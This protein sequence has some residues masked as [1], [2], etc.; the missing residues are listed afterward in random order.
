MDTIE[1]QITILELL[2]MSIQDISGDERY[3]SVCLYTDQLVL[4]SDSSDLPFAAAASRLGCE[5]AV[6][7]RTKAFLCSNV[8]NGVDIS[9]SQIPIVP[10]IDALDNA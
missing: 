6:K 8:E 9:G 1:N 3:T 5:V 7:A 2:E 10:C 4:T